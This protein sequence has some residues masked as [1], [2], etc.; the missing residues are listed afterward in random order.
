[1]PILFSLVG[2]VIILILFNVIVFRNNFCKYIFLICGIIFECGFFFGDFTFVDVSFNVFHLILYFILFAFVVHDLR[3]IDVICSMLFSLLF[4]LILS[5][6]N[7]QFFE[8][9][10]N[11][12]ICILFIRCFCFSSFNRSFSFLLMS[13]LGVTC[14]NLFYQIEML[15]IA[16]INFIDLYNLIFLFLVFFATI[17]SF[18]RKMF[19]DKK[20]IF[21]YIF[22]IAYI[23]FAHEHKCFSKR[24]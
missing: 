22:D 18:R 5:L 9:F 24:C 12:F 2:V 8:T 20:S 13:L 11:I 21:N 7:F 15:T 1:M 16:E 6:L 17:H 19:Y 23:N 3:I 14:V 10:Y 4:Y